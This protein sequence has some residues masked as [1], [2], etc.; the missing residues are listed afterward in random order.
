LV[1]YTTLFRSSVPG[2]EPVAVKVV[3]P[4]YTT[5]ANFRAAFR[6]LVEEAHELDSPYLGRVRAADLDGAV[7][8]VAI[9]RPPGPSLADLVRER[10]PLP[11]DALHPLALAV[12]PGLAA[13]HATGRVHAALWPDGILRSAEH[14][15][16]ADPALERAAPH[17]EGRAP[18][19]SSVAPEGGATPATDV[20]SWAATL[21]LAAGG[22]EGPEGLPKVP[23]QLRGLVE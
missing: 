23:L 7:P 14:A 2:A 21:S 20:F 22:V 5:D 17:P 18:P 10:G 3:R 9:S 19:P 8:W 4:E 1:P 16:R 11:A 12:A 15:R 13:L 6:R